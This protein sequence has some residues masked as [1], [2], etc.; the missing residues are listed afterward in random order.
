MRITGITIPDDKRLEYGLTVLHGIG[1]S[2]AQ[3]VLD[4]LG[5]DRAK[6]AKDV[7]ADEE[8]N[9]RQ[10]LEAFVLEGDLKREKSAHIKRLKDIRAHRG[11]RHARNLPVRGQRTKSNSRTVRGNKRTTMGSGKTKVS[12]T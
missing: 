3:K 2:R 9:I 5:I 12:K 6:K 4:T 8:Q 7:T 11:T 1:L 10:A